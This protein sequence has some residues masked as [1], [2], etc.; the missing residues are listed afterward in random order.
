MT[1]RNERCR[2]PTPRRSNCA[3]VIV[4]VV[5]SLLL[6]LLQP[7]CI[8]LLVNSEAI[9]LVN[10]NLPT[11]VVDRRRT[12]RRRFLQATAATGLLGSVACTGCAE[13]S[14]LAVGTIGDAHCAQ[15]AK[16]QTWWPC[17][18]GTC[19]YYYLTTTN[20]IVDQHV[21]YIT[22]HPNNPLSHT[23]LLLKLY[24]IHLHTP[25]MA[26]LFYSC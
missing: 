2:R 19:I 1:T 12:N 23:F 15:C 25:I 22:T 8:L 13:A 18:Q 17:D 16:G 24:V 5:S 7:W 3:S 9:P 14:C 10:D 11:I 20:I 21:V 6:L 26:S 4:V